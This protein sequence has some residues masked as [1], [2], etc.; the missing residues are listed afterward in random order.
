MDGSHPKDQKYQL[1]KLDE[2]LSFPS[3]AYLCFW[4][5]M[6][7]LSWTT[8]SLLPNILYKFTVVTHATSRIFWYI[9]CFITQKYR[10]ETA[11]AALLQNMIG[12]WSD[13]KSISQLNCLLLSNMHIFYKQN[14]PSPIPYD[15]NHSISWLI[16]PMEPSA[17]NWAHGQVSFLP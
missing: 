1:W 4:S 3:P 10:K 12:I 13:L 9:S 17:I 8:C 11:T 14:S 5:E 7:I 6:I 2:Y 15:Q 16:I